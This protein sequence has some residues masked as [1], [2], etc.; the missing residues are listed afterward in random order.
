MKTI[1]LVFQALIRANTVSFCTD[2]IEKQS[3]INYGQAPSRSMLD[4]GVFTNDSP[5][6]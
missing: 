3:E 5:F 1:S 2:M 4:R 6:R